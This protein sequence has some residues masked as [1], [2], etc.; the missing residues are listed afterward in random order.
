MS[1]R[2]GIASGAVAALKEAVL[3]ERTGELRFVDGD[4]PTVV[5]IEG[6]KL[7]LGRYL[8][9]KVRVACGLAETASLVSAD[10]RQRAQE[11][12]RLQV[13]HREFMR[14]KGLKRVK[15][16]H[17]AEALVRLSRERKTDEAV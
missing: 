2:P 6:K 12:E 1:R 14:R 10:L 3:D 11:A 5:R 7:P 9:A 16:Q 15:S 4:V 17:R 13:G 8:R